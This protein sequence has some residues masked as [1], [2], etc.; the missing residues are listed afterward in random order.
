MFSAVFLMTAGLPLKIKMFQNIKVSIMLLGGGLLPHMLFTILDL[1]KHPLKKSPQPV[2]NLGF[3]KN[4]RNIRIMNSTNTLA[5]RK[6][7]LSQFSR[8]SENLNFKN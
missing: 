5:E 2:M 7:H 3:W 6:S 4:Q 8:I 1:G